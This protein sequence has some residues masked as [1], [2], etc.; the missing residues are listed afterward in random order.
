MIGQRVAAGLTAL[1]FSA[2]VHARGD[3]LQSRVVVDV[4]GQPAGLVR[5]ESI[6]RVQDDRL[7]ALLSPCGGPL[8]V[9]EERKQERLRFPRPRTGR[10]DGGLRRLAIG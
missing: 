9:V 4:L 10:D 5:D 7:D 3:V 2:D 8:S 6:H 1:A